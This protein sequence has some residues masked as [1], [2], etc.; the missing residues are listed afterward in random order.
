MKQNLSRTPKPAKDGMDAAACE[1]ADWPLEQVKQLARKLYV[2]FPFEDD[3]LNERWKDLLRCAFWVFDNLDEA[4]KEI[5]KERSD[6]RRAS[7]SLQAAYQK[8]PASVPFKKALQHITG[9]RTGRA[10]S[11]FNKV[12][13][14]DARNDWGEVSRKLTSGQKL[15]LQAQLK[16]WKEKGIL[17]QDVIQLQ[18]LYKRC[19]PLV[20]AEQ[21]RAKAKRRGG[22]RPVVET[23]VR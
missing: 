19:W 4:C 15:R 16:N 3:P 10:E 20:V 7:A 17:R 14:Y 1:K 23:D 21:N 12:L 9:K 18:S 8:L 6:D 22:K 13:S 11:N 2:R 5:L